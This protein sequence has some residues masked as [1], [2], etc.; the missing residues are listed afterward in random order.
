MLSRYIYL[1]TRVGS[2]FAGELSIGE[3]LVDGGMHPSTWDCCYIPRY[4]LT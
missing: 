1:G 4:M 3:V 2:C